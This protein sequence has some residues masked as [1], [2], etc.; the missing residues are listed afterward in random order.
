MRKKTTVERGIFKQKI[1]A[2]LY[3]S[4]KIKRLLL[5]DTSGESASQVMKDFKK[6]VKSHL[7]VEDTI[8]DTGTYIFY[9]V[10]MPNLRSQIKDCQVI[11]YLICHRDMIDS[12][13]TEEGC[14]GNQVDVLSQLVEET[15]LDEETVNDFGIGELTLDGIDI[16]NATRFYGCIMTF[17]VPNFR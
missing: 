15:L 14:Y 9:D 4:D 16:Y 8:K 6:Y 1:H 17:F 10:I 11:M 12:G 2:A 13:Y 7:F 5:G 3:K